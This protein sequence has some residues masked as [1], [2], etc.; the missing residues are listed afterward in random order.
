MQWYLQSIAEIATLSDTSW[1]PMNLLVKV[2][3]ATETLKI[4]WS[5]VFLELQ[6]HEE[7]MLKCIF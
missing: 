3:Q 1:T 2:L 5:N 4:G 6:A 7:K